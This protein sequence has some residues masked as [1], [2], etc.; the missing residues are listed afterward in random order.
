MFL[1]WWQ[2]FSAVPHLQLSLIFIRAKLKYSEPFRV[3]TWTKELRTSKSKTNQVLFNVF[4]T[5]NFITLRNLSKQIQN[6]SSKVT[7]HRINY[8]SFSKSVNEF[9][10]RIFITRR[11]NFISC[12]LESHPDHLRYRIKPRKLHLFSLHKVDNVFKLM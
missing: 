6:N 3:N 7:R 8:L 2:L 9:T 5:T 1:S 11:R 12:S 10:A 4:L